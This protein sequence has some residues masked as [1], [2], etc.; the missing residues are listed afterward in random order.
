LG[1]FCECFGRLLA[2]PAHLFTKIAQ[3]WLYYL[4]LT[5]VIAYLSGMAL[6]NK[7]WI[8]ALRTFP[9]VQLIEGMGI[10]SPPAEFLLSPMLPI[11]W[12]PPL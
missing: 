4:R 10:V 2:I 9:A 5:P 6:S 3:S 8:E 7:L 11:L 1:K 12:L